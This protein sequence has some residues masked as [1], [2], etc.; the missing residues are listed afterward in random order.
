MIKELKEDL[1]NLC[2]F[3]LLKNQGPFGDLLIP[4][5]NHSVVVLISLLEFVGVL[6]GSFIRVFLGKQSVYLVLILT[7]FVVARKMG[8]QDIRDEL[9]T[10]VGKICLRLYLVRTLQGLINLLVQDQIDLG[11]EVVYFKEV[12]LEWV[13]FSSI[14]VELLNEFQNTGA[15]ELFCFCYFLVQNRFYL[16]LGFHYRT[17]VCMGNLAVLNFKHLAGFLH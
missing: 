17:V 9:L 14:G 11:D 15:A 4:I 12:I 1:V 7:H 5:F 13:G 6:N 8:K 2:L 3:L 10:Y 16:Q